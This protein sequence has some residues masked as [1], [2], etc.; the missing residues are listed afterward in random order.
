[1]AACAAAEAGRLRL[2]EK[3]LPKVQCNP[4]DELLDYGLVAFTGVR[5]GASQ[6]ADFAPVA[7][8]PGLTPTSAPGSGR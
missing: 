2:P 7:S 3:D 8:Y 6:T 1:M 4:T 5:L